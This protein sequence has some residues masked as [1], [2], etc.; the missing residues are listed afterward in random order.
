MILIFFALLPYN[1]YLQ[2]SFKDNLN[3]TFHGF[4]FYSVF[5]WFV[6][7]KFPNGGSILGSSKFSLLPQLPPKILLD[8]KMV[9]LDS[10]IIISLFL[11]IFLVC[12]IWLPVFSHFFYNEPELGER[13]NPNMALTPLP[14]SIGQELN[15]R[16]SDCD[17]SA[18]LLDHDFCLIISLY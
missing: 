7:A 2:W 17:P 6:Q 14:S 11:N 3:R 8:S 13:I 4:V 15:P 1:F 5:H 12:P 9:K 10:K 16:P 18:L